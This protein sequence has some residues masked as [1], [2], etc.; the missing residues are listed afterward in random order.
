MLDQM[1]DLERIGTVLNRTIRAEDHMYIRDTPEHYFGV[2]RSA[3]QCIA[4]MMLIAD[5]RWPS[6]V[7]DFASGSGRVTRWLRA[8]F[9]DA[10]LT[11]SDI[12]VPALA[13]LAQNFDVEPWESSE[14]LSSL[15]P[16]RP[17][18][19]IWCGSLV[20]TAIILVRY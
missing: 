8:V 18:D 17:F 13:W 6:S 12:R 3:I 7:L 1:P 5:A 20:T 15:K 16:P 19:I 14:D 11:V 4:A 10:I 2:G 9:P